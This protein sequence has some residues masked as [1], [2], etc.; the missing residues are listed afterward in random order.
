M[1]YDYEKKTKSGKNQKFSREV[2]EEN[3]ESIETNSFS[4]KTFSVIH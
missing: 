4:L 3:F 2:Q 1:F